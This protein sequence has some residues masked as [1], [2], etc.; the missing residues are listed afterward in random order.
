MTVTNRGISKAPQRVATACADS[1]RVAYSIYCISFAGQEANRVRGESMRAQVF[2]D[3][4]TGG[5]VEVSI[6]KHGLSC[7][8]GHK[9]H[10]IGKAKAVLLAFGFDAGLVDCQLEALSVTP[11]SVLLRFPVVEIADDVLRS[12]GFDAAAWGLGLSQRNFC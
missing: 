2:I 11:P 12:F 9:Y 6:V 7:G 10:A 4:T 5:L 1:V 8:V 3:H